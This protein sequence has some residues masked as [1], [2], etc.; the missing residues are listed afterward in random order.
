MDQSGPNG[1]FETRVIT[2]QAGFFVDAKG[3][4]PDVPETIGSLT[5][6]NSTVVPAHGLNMPKLSSTFQVTK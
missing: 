5:F 3:A 1:D 6:I 4:R 2:V